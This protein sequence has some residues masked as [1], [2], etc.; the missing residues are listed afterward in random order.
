MCCGIDFGTSNTTMAVKRD[1]SARLVPLEHDHLT[2]PT[3]LFFPEVRDAP[4]LFGRAAQRAYLDGVEGRYLRSLKRLLGTSLMTQTTLLQGARWQFPNIIAAFLRHIKQTAEQQM[5][6]DITDVTIGRPVHFQDNN[7][8]ADKEAEK[9]LHDIAT[10]VGFKDIRFQFEPVAAA[11]A[12]EKHITG[13][14]LALVVDIGGGT[15]DFSVL[16]LSNTY[17]PDRNRAQDILANAGIRIGGNDCDRALNLAALMPLLGM[18]SRF[19]EKELEFPSQLFFELSE[20]AKVNWCYTPHNSQFVHDTIR[21]S[22]APDQLQ[23]L[24]HVL[25][26]QWGHRLLDISETLKIELSADKV[27]Q[28]TLNFLEKGLHTRMTQAQMNRLCAKTWAPVRT[29]M[30]HTIKQAGLK[31]DAIEAVILT[32]GST[33]L[34]VFQEWVTALFPTADIFQE[35]KLGSVGLGLVG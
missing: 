15:S 16:R 24:L 11:L 22:T 10:Q 29:A 19:G 1:G 18:G 35:D 34:P 5:Q 17:K 2:I 31:P 32:G 14:K 7:S 33:A 9:Q 28:Q 25:E 26:Y 12:H 3:A 20:W 30:I 23:R 21:T 6:Q 13:E 8:E 27:S 4:I